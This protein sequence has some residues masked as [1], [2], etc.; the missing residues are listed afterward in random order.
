MRRSALCI[1]MLQL[2]NARGILGK[3]ELAKE[4][5]TN[6]RNI[7]E[8]KKE[9]EDAGYFIES[10]PGRY[11]GYKLVDSTLLPV[12]A[13]SQKEKKAL[14]ESYD[15]IRSHADFL[16]QKE[17][18]QAMDKIKVQLN[19]TGKSDIYMNAEEGMISNK[20][21]GMIQLCEEAKKHHQ[22]LVI[23]YKGMNDSKPKKIMIHPYEI[24]YYHNAYYCLAYSLKAKDFRNYKFSEERM[25]NLE[26]QPAFFLRDREFNIKQHIGILGLMKN[27][28]HEFELLIYGEQA[29]LVAERKVG[30]HP[31]MQ[32]IDDTTL[33]LCT[34]MEGKL[35][36][37][38]FILSLG[39]QVKVL[40]PKYLC[41]EIQSIVEKMYQQLHN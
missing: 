20:L 10:I 1:R 19:E 32:W 11:G 2:L 9:L 17:L 38:S 33:H 35:D 30:I 4:L 27:D 21:K 23:E 13:F 36:V 39:N 41:D 18:T 16:L 28:V 6:K 8:F 37:I 12:L 26:L 3:E 40:A 29:L 15:Y 31:Q 5:Q 34:I 14:F 24:L 25:K 22:V 7:V